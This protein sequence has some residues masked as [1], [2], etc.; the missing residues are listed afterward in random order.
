[1]TMTKKSGGFWNYDCWWLHL[2]L[3]LVILNTLQQW[4]CC[5][6]GWSW[7]LSGDE[8][9]CWI[10]VILQTIWWWS[11][12][13]WWWSWRE[14]LCRWVWCQIKCW[15]WRFW[16]LS[17]DDFENSGDESG[18][19]SGNLETLCSDES[20]TDLLSRQTMSR[21]AKCKR[22]VQECKRQWQQHVRCTRALREIIS[23][24]M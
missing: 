14:I 1:M 24:G 2:L 3:N 19:E 11:C 23:Y 15:I 22:V 10:L 16:K 18:V 7:T 13:Q 21:D 5:W 4:I 6:I 8:S 20:D 12:C 17:G 9:G